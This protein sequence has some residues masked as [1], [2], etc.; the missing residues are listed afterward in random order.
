PL[1]AALSLGKIK[2]LV[3]D[4]KVLTKVKSALT[5]VLTQHQISLR[6][7][8]DRKTYIVR[9]D[10]DGSLIIAT[11]KGFEHLDPNNILRILWEKKEEEQE[12]EK[13]KKEAKDEEKEEVK[14]EEKVEIDQVLLSSGERLTGRLEKLEKGSAYLR[15]TSGEQ[16]VIPASMISAVSLKSR[17]SSMAGDRRSGPGEIVTRNGSRL[18]GKVL[19]VSG[20]TVS[21]DL[22]GQSL[23]LKRAE[24]VELRFNSKASGEQMNELGHFAR[25]HLKGGDRL[26]GLLL[27]LEKDRIQLGSQTLGRVWVERAR[28]SDIQFSSSLGFDSDVTVIANYSGN[29][30]RFV[31]LKGKIIKDISIPESPWDVERLQHGHLLVALYRRGSVIE[32]DENGKEIWRVSGFSQPSD[33]DRLPNG[34]TLICDRGRG[35]IIEV[36]HNRNVV[37][38]YSGIYASEVERLANGHTLMADSNRG[39]LI[40]IDAF[41]N[42]VW[43]LAGYRNPQDIDVLENGHILLV[44]G[45]NRVIEI[46]RSGRIFWEKKG[47]RS[48]LDADRLENGN[49]LITESSGNKVIEVAPDGTIVRTI[50]GL[51]YPSQAQRR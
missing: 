3:K 14:D 15:W 9:L 5:E 6:Q 16:I 39:R 19:G 25:V 47:L 51:N 42:V 43:E 32:L 41:G 27:A 12:K 40:E 37:F 1:K 8:K 46:D 34:H 22:D 24:I 44:E 23:P 48:P 2:E 4:V 33:V 45:H 29:S 28:L 26:W 49:T 13:G 50:A 17:L 11:S 7:G 20:K 30:I 31:D 18:I 38:Q 21:F 10:Q 36:D 35:K